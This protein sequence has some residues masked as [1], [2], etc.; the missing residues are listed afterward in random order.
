M[1]VTINTKQ[2]PKQYI[3]VAE[4]VAA[5]HES[6][7]AFQVLESSPLQVGERVL[8]RVVVTVDDKQY[9]GTAEVHLSAP[10]N[11]PEGG[12]QFETAETS[13]IGRALGFANFGVIDSIAS[14]DEIVH[15]QP[16]TPAPAP[17]AKPAPKS[18]GLTLGKLK[19]RAQDTGW[20]RDK[21]GWDIR[22][23][24]IFGG[25]VP[26]DEELAKPESL[27]LI[28]F[29]LEQFVQAAPAA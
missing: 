13:A 4:R 19:H 22:I 28:N 25:T 15:S 1:S 10:K 29:H 12:A 11:T 8:W 26:E 16:A 14:A 2:G 18:N 7:K 23:A 17:A 9:I 24:S 20:A 6:G 5:V 3:T 21:A 27:A